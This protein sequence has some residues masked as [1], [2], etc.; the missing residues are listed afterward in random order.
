MRHTSIVTFQKATIS[1]LLRNYS[2]ATSSNMDISGE[3][4]TT[5]D[6]V[7][8]FYFG[9]FFFI[10]LELLTLYTCSIYL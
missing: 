9:C 5:Q 10:D 4:L 2:K 3:N 7:F 6:K 1:I 8:M